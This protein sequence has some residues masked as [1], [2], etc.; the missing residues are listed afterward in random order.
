MLPEGLF[1]V[2]GWMPDTP[3]KWWQNRTTKEYYG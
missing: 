2:R 1:S 3:S